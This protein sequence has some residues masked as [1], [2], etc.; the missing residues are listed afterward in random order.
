MSAKVESTSSPYL[1]SSFFNIFRELYSSE[2]NNCSYNLELLGS[3]TKLKLIDKL[4]E[5]LIKN[6]FTHDELTQSQ[7][8]RVV[9]FVIFTLNSF[10]EDSEKIIL[11]FHEF[12]WFEFKNSSQNSKAGINEKKV[13]LLKEWENVLN[14]V[15]PLNLHLEK[16]SSDFP[17][18]IADLM[19]HKRFLFRFQRL[20]QKCLYLIY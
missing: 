3:I 8:S 14:K 12:F 1:S 5:K 20:E 16:G 13:I 7:N 2:G 9:N 11:V 10:L 4:I 15:G 17:D 6:K 18:S 19:S